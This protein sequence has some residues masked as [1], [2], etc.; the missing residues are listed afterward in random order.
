MPISTRARSRRLPS[1]IALALA[2]S[3]VVVQLPDSSAARS[4]CFGRDATVRGTS[5]ADKLIGT[6]GGD[7]F[8]A[9][10]GDDVVE[11]RGGDDVICG[12]DGKDLLLGAAGGDRIDG[13]EG[14]DDLIGS[15]GDDVLIDRGGGDSLF[16]G[17]GDDLLRAGDGNELLVPGPGGDRISGGA[18]VDE[19]SFA[20]SRG[21]IVASLT[22]GTATGEGADA[23]AG[24]EWLRGSSREDVLTGDGAANRLRGELGADTLVGSDGDDLLSGGLGD[25][26]LDGGPGIDTASFRSALLGVFADLAAGAARG[27]GADRLIGVEH[28]VGSE[29]Q[30]VLLGDAGP[31]WIVGGAAA[32]EVHGRAGDDRL[33]ASDGTNDGGPGIDACLWG[34]DNVDCERTVTY[35][36]LGPP[37][38]VLTRPHDEQIIENR[39]FSAIEVGSWLR[40]F[41]ALRRLTASGCR[42]LDADREELVPGH[43]A[44]PSWNPA[45]GDGGRWRLVVKRPLPEGIYSVVVGVRSRP[46]RDG[47][48]TRAMHAEF[49]LI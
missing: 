45:Q 47:R 4:G 9:G 3:V 42:W 20:F 34:D 19:A 35:P 10:A 11:G 7:V 40:V 43:C 13:G 2:M 37:L 23:I 22:D 14:A 38:A 41:V 6:R 8:A 27:D 26:V 30:D 33:E 46:G 25:D 28:L 29:F 1:G 18:G 44:L 39:A 21:P 15:A 49:R 31:N 32:D 5:G 36:V 16:G 17:N 24:V 48:I 12:G